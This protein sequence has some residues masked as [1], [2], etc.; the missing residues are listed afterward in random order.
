MMHDDPHPTLLELGLGFA[1]G[2]VVLVGS[3]IGLS[4]AGVRIGDPLSPLG[5]LLAITVQSLAVLA[6]MLPLTLRRGSR[7][8]LV[9]G[10]QR[11]FGRRPYLWIAPVVLVA[12]IGHALVLALQSLT[13][14]EVESPGAAL[15][16]AVADQPHGL[17]ALILGAVVLAP[18][19]EELLFRGLLFGW[20]RRH[21]PLAPA[22]ALQ[23]IPFGLLHGGLDY[24]LYACL[25][26]LVLAVVREWTGSLRVPI[27]AHLV[28]N[29]TAVF[30]AYLGAAAT[31]AGSPGP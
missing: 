15:L 16:Q 21:L 9:L 31:E 11:P 22:A 2:G 7:S 3:I 13:G 26:G 19:S 20:L 5:L 18:L 30:F 29:A 6:A 14:R 1:L 4:G 17:A 27:A 8:V 24:A 12:V 25:L 28:V 10:L 23:A